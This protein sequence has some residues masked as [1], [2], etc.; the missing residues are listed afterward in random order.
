MLENG[1]IV[2]KV[3]SAKLQIKMDLF[4]KDIGKKI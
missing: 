2:K 3:D 1:K 4:T